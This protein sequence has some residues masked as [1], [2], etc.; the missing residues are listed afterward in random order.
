[1]EDWDAEFVGRLLRAHGRE[2]LS[3]ADNVGSTKLADIAERIR[4]CM[5]VLLIGSGAHSA[6]AL[7]VAAEI[8]RTPHPPAVCVWSSADIRPAAGVIRIQSMRD[9]GSVLRGL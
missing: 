7:S 6:E 8:A 5:V 4:A 9:L 2:V 3:P 1:V